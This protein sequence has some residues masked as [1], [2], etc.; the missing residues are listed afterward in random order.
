MPTYKRLFIWVEGDD[1]ERFVNRVLVPKFQEK[2]DDVKIVKYAA[3]EKKKLYDFIKSIEAMKSDYIYLTDINNSPCITAKKIKVQSKHENVDNDKIIIVVKEI[4][5][6]YLAGLDNEVCKQLKIKNFTTT[7]DITKEKF[8]T[9]IPKKFTSRIDFMSEVLKNF[10]I[11]VA[12]HKNN[13]FRY[14]VEKYD[15]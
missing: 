15:C 10:S 1:D 2:Y 9:L 3:M 13:S 8:N 4:E 6:W 11:E 12:K 7:D 5:S 14:F